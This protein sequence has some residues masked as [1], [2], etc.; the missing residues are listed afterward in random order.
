MGGPRGLQAIPNRWSCLGLSPRQFAKQVGVTFSMAQFVVF[1]RE[2]QHRPSGP[3]RKARI[4]H[5]ILATTG[6]ET[7]RPQAKLHEWKS[8]TCA[9]VRLSHQITGH[10]NRKEPPREA[11]SEPSQPCQRHV[12]GPPQRAHEYHKPL[13]KRCQQ[14]LPIFLKD[15]TSKADATP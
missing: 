10:L 5:S 2:C 1:G 7:N 15:H 3:R 11:Q 4:P 6:Q 12:W 14:G 8:E 9:R 13:Q